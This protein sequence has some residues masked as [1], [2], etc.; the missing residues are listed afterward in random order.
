MDQAF[1]LCE[2][3]LSSSLQVSKENDAAHKDDAIAHWQSGKLKDD[4]DESEWN[5]FDETAEGEARSQLEED[6][7]REGK[8]KDRKRGRN[9]K[10]STE[11]S[12][13]AGQLAGS[14]G[15]ELLQDSEDDNVDGKRHQALRSPLTKSSSICMGIS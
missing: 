10:R 5:G 12:T 14:E 4:Q 8:P 11:T 3:K 6:K 15:F 13:R 9:T 7:K 2:I 1:I